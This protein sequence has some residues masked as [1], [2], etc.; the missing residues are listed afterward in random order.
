VE[1]AQRASQSS[2]NSDPM[3]LRILAAAYAEAGRYS[4]AV[5]TAQRASQIAESQANPMLAARLRAQ[6]E[7]YQAGTPLRVPALERTPA[8]HP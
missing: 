8:P 6:V 1:L 2:G 3:I 4:D 7:L 5:E